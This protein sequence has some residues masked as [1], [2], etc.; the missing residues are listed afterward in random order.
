[1]NQSSSMKSILA[2]F[3]SSLILISCQGYSVDFVLKD[4]N[5]GTY[6]LK[7]TK[8]DKT[9]CYI[10]TVGEVGEVL[11]SDT[12]EVEFDIGVEYLSGTTDSL[13]LRGLRY[14]S[15]KRGREFAKIKDEK[16]TFDLHDWGHNYTGTGYLGGGKISLQ[17][18]YQYRATEI[19]F[20][21]TGEKIDDEVLR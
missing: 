8:I 14:A 5:T 17:T 6:H 18:S 19:E 4:V 13:R 9:I 10:C 20:N 12:T 3:I 16:L 1:M 21:L 2:F 7:G 11:S 15:T